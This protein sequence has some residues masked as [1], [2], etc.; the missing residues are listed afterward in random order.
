MDTPSPAAPAPSNVIPLRPAQPAAPAK[1]AKA[2]KAE[3]AKY[4]RPYLKVAIEACARE[5]R[6]PADYYLLIG[7]YGPE[8]GMLVPR[9]LA[10]Q[11]IAMFRSPIG[12]EKM[13]K[14]VGMRCEPKQLLV[15]ITAGDHVEGDFIR[16]PT[17][18]PDPDKI[19][20]TRAEMDAIERYQRLYAPSFSASVDGSGGKLADY[21]AILLLPNR[22]PILIERKNAREALEI[23]GF[24]AAAAE[25][26]VPATNDD[27]L[28]CIYM[29][30]GKP[31]WSRLQY[32][33][34]A[35]R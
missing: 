16:V 25:L 34:R 27:E 11:T 4:A 21:V 24:G 15:I 23:S 13:R 12:R 26:D 5:H 31:S 18:A 33:A 35:T 8:E 2:N 30:K 14:L 3:V 9:A 28:L 10:E 22:R 32:P 29:V 6:D 20:F 19:F 17:I 7:K 1:N